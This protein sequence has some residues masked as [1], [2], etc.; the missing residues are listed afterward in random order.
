[1]S[2]WSRKKVLSAIALVLLLAI[3]VGTAFARVYTVATGEKNGL[4]FGAMGGYDCLPFWIPE[5]KET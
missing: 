4:A 1:M 5:K 2:R 3:V